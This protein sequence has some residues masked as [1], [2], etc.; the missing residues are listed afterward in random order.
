[1]HS[2]K[3]GS[4]NKKSLNH[5][6]VI[7]SSAFY[8]CNLIRFNILQMSTLESDLL[9]EGQVGRLCLRNIKELSDKDVAFLHVYITTSGHQLTKLEFSNVQLPLYLL[10]FIMQGAPNITHILFNNT[11]TMQNN[12]LKKVECINLTKLEEVSYASC[13]YAIEFLFTIMTENTF[14]KVV[15]QFSYPELFQQLIKRQRKLKMLSVSI[16]GDLCRVD[17]KP[18]NLNHTKLTR[19]DLF[20]IIESPECM[21]EILKHQTELQ[22]FNLARIPLNCNMIKSIC[23]MTNLIELTINTKLN[24]PTAVYEGFSN[25]KNLHSLIIN[26]HRNYNFTDNEQ[27]DDITYRHYEEI[28]VLSNVTTMNLSSL[29]ITYSESTLHPL[30]MLR[31]AMNNPQLMSVRIDAFPGINFS[32]FLQHCKKLTMFNVFF[33]EYVPKNYYKLC[34]LRNEHFM[35]SNLEIFRANTMFFNFKALKEFVRNFPNLKVLQILL[36]EPLTKIQLKSLLVNLKHLTT[37]YVSYHYLDEFPI[38]IESFQSFC[39]VVIKRHSF[40]L[41]TMFIQS[42]TIL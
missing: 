10:L 15:A 11:K 14:V 41:K 28:E 12:E 21:E 29:E 4:L 22:H 37:L 8:F 3:Q 27:L 13:D 9:S 19:L 17:W 7:Q 33:A 35:N 26:N 16:S 40:P 23:L 5:L 6:M 30:C 38:A 32:H 20:L 42:F 2:R 31:F 39:R 34:D 18:F 36:P 24:I 1:M 25:L